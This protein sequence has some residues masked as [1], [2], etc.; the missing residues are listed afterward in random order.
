MTASALPAA[1]W[2]L[3]AAAVALYPLPTPAVARVRLLARTDSVE[4][5]R[6]PLGLR[7]VA[8]VDAG[9]ATIAAAGAGGLAV[10]G[11][12]GPALGVTTGVIVATVA[13]MVRS[14]LR[15]RAAARR[16]HDLLLAIRLLE[17]ELEAGAGPTSALAAAAQAS[18]AHAEVFGAAAREAAGGRPVPG[19]L[20]DGGAEYAPLA[21]AW[22]LADSAGVPL[23]SALTSVACDLAARDHQAR[24][25]VVALAGARASALLVSSLP[26]LGLALGSAMG[27]R[28][29]SFL[30]DSPA[31][32]LVCCA[33]V[34]LDA[35]GIAWIQGIIRRA[36]RV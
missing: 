13:T 6:R 22:A 23:A 9:K 33:G 16:R 34:L 12:R 8:R 29:L 30:L 14:R 4:V 27:A 10:G 26:L 15:D 28:P 32:R 3:V 21:H 24:E 31:G 11:V 35:A 36:E 17:G 19:V 1:C 18:S 25:V 7:W 5:D 2:A 20:I